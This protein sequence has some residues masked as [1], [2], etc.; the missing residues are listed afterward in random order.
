M[1]WPQQLA[2]RPSKGQLMLPLPTLY[3]LFLNNK[4]EGVVVVREDLKMKEFAAVMVEGVQRRNG[5]GR[6]EALMAATPTL[7]MVLMMPMVMHPVLLPKRRWMICTCS[8]LMIATAMCLCGRKLMFVLC[9][10]LT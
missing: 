6:S 5:R 3:L 7:P 1:V 10:R 8:T 4:R 2:P 9:L